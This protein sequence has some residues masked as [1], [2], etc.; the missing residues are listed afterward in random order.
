MATPTLLANA[1][2]GVATLDPGTPG[3]E[4][5]A[6]HARRAYSDL[7][8]LERILSRTGRVAAVIV[9]PVAGNMGVVCPPA[10]GLRAQ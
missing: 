7:E 1:G 10:G 2:S 3:T 9:E 6:R 5:R 8:A 4:G